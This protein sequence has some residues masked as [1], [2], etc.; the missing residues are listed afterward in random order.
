[1]GDELKISIT[2]LIADGSNWVTY[3]DRMLW[4][5]DSRGLSEHLTNA[6]ITATYTA[7]GTV[8]SV[9]PQ[10]RWSG[11]QAMVKQLIAISVPDT[12][13][14]SI[15]TGTTAKDVWDALKKLYEG[16]TMLITIDLGRRLQTTRCGEDES[17]REHFERLGDMREQLAAMG[18]SIADEEYASI[19]MGS[20]PASYAP[21][22]SGISAAAEIS[23]TTPTVVMVTKLAIDEYDR[24]TLGNTKSDEAFAAD[25]KRKGKKRDVE[26]FNCHKRG[27]MKADCWA[28]GGG[29]EGQGPRRRRNS[30]KDGGKKADTAAGA[31]QAGDKSAGGKDKDEDVEAWAVVEEEEDED[32]PPQIPAMAANEARDAEVELFDS[33]AS[34]HMS[35]F[36]ERFVTYR[37]IPA[38]PITAANNRAFYAVGMGDLEIDVPNGASSTKVLL[39]DALYAPDLGLTVVSI[40][41]IVKAGCTVEFEGGTCKIKRDG[42]VI[43]NVPASANGLFKVEHALAAAESIERVDIL[44][45]HR[46]L[47]HIA[48][49]TIRNLVRNKAIAGIH[50]I[51]DNP[52]LACDSCEYAK[53]TRKPIQKQRE[54]PQATAFGDEIHSDV[55]GPSTPESLGGRKY[56]VTFTDDYS[57]Y[58][59]IQ[60]LHTKDETFGAYKTFAAWAKTQHGVRVK[61]LRSDRGGEY[62]G[63]KFSAFLQKQGTERRLTTHGT[64]QHNGVAE[65]LNRR[66]F[67][68]VRAML[69]Q[70]DLP[71][72]LWAEAVQF[73]TWLKNRTSTKAIGN[74]TPYERLYNEVPNLGGVPEWGQHVWVYNATGG[75]LDARANQARWVGYDADSTHAH[76]IYW[77]STKRISVERDVKFVSSFITVHTPPPSYSSATLPVTTQPAPTPP[78][79]KAQLPTAPLVPTP[80]AQQTSSPS[81]PHA[82]PPRTPIITRSRTIQQPPPAPRR[83]GVSTTIRPHTPPSPLPPLTPSEPSEEEHAPVVPSTPAPPRMSFADIQVPRRSARIPIASAW[84]R[85]LEAGEGTEGEEYSDYVFSAAFDDII[86]AAFLDAEIDPKSLAEAQSSPDWSHWKKAMD[87]ELGTLEKAGTWFNVPRP[88][89]KNIVGSKWVYR[90]KHNADGSVDKYKARLVA[91]GFTQIYGVD[92]FTTFSPVAKLSSFRTILAIAARHDWE[93]ESFDFNAAYLNGELDDDEEIYMYPPPGYDSDPDIVKR[94]RKALYG[95]K[96]AG[97]KWYDTLS[98]ALADIGF[99]VSQADPGVFIAKISE[100][101]LILAVHVDDC[102]FTGSSALLITEY[103]DKI[104]S[105][106]AFKDLGPISW[107][108]GIRVT[109]NRAERTISLSQTTYIDSILSRFAL[110]DAKPCTSPMIPGIVYTKDQ[111]PNSPEEAVQMKKTPYREAIGSLMYVAVAT[112]PDIAFA[113]SALSQFLSNPGRAHWE[114]V[115]RVF[116]YLSGTKTL[117]LTY[118]GERHGLEGYTDADGATQEHRHAMSGYAF[119]IDGGAV[120]W[121]SRKQEL[122]TL[123]TA[124]AEYVAATHAAKEAIW[125][126]KLIGELFPNLIMP[127]PLHCDNQAALKLATDDNY[128]AR[129]KHIDIRYHFIRHV[130]ATGALKLSYCPTEDMVADIFTKA[131][132]KWK[133][134]AHVHSLGMCNTCGGVMEDSTQSA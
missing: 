121:S 64:P 1:M 24:R 105:C 37:D 96:Q 110:A 28:K 80:V 93:I 77:P 33:G 56:Y 116:K 94:L 39:R 101:I 29:K 17:V 4:A 16:R 115:K 103:K 73:A 35:P 130:V 9:T 85:Q 13:F 106:Y 79:S 102:I 89:D 81:A 122:V 51:D 36:R 26:C 82:P 68:R 90:I 43:G 30:S 5:I 47:G 20:L 113:V 91:R 100:D 48:L 45:L 10:M 22:L 75:K 83:P 59:W 84:R 109:R 112:R 97:R 69:H 8:G 99:S 78:A 53:T 54:G 31:E 124:E 88:P 74:V 76:R 119:L 108:L 134:A 27:H 92:Y 104:N 46:R 87:R 60:P 14:N 32:E 98:R 12:V 95:L 127:T 21:T 65:S 128:H 123:S 49:N 129:T 3:R 63:R 67:D 44:T 55:W 131:L 19:L 38:R 40:G 15:K 6:T 25:A 23:A 111:S 125:L 2:K 34:R 86:T 70:A 58:S 71:K 52:S 42:H 62:T 18:K 126:R 57:R 41:R 133:V 114:A 50:L 72:N 118:G 66:L 7:V 117:E 132:P 61:R 11:D 120:S 107:L